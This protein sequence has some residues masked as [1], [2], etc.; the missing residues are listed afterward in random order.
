[1]TSIRLVSLAFLPVVAGFGLCLASGAP[2]GGAP[3]DSAKAAGDPARFLADAGSRVDAALGR[4][5]LAAYRG[6]LK[7][8]RLDAQTEALRGG[9]SSEPA[10][11]KAR[12]LDDWVRRI[13]DNPGLIG[14][15][16]GVEEWAYESLVDDSGQPFR[17][18]IPTDYD[19]AHP[20]PL[21]VYMHGYS[22][23]HIEHSAGMVP[24]PGYF[25]VSVLGRSR[26]GGFR[27]LSEADVLQVVDYVTAHWAIDPDR[28]SL[29]GGS[30][31]GGATYRLGSRYPQL[32]CSGRT[33][34]GFASYLPLGNLVTLPIYATHSADDPTVSVLHDRGPLARLREIG[35]QVIY[36]ETNGYGHAVWN[37]K[38]GNARGLAWEQFQVRPA[39]RTVRRVDYTALDGGAVRGWWGEVAEWGA[40]PK[41]ARFV[42]AAGN[43]NLLF[44][45]LTNIARLRLFLSESPFERSM[46]LEVSVNGAVPFTLPAPLPES[47]VIALGEKGWGPESKAEV[48]P[49]RLHTPGS[50]VLLYDGEP[51]LIVY[52]TRGSETERKAMRAAAEAASKGPGPAWPDEKVEAG[53]DKVPHN[54]NLYGR[55]NIKADLDVTA[56]DVARCHLVLIGTAAQN[57]VV[58][59]MADALPVRFSDTGVTCSDGASFRGGRLAMGLVH[60]NPLAPGRLIFWVASGD[61]AAYA[62]NSAIPLAMSGGERVPNPA[63]AFGADLV[64]MSA[65]SPTLVAARSFDSR[66]RWVPG[67]GESPLVPGNIANPR[68]LSRAVGEAI[69][70]AAG[71]DFALVKTD[72]PLLPPSATAGVT[73]VSD[74][75]PFFSNTPVGEFEASGAELLEIARLAAAKDPGLVMP[76]L[77]AARI[78]AARAYRVAL[79]VN[80]L[81]YF[82]VAVQPAPRNY[83]ITGLDAGDAVERF[84]PLEAGG[85][86]AP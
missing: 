22:G 18:D 25:E 81:W 42:L 60:Y 69:R 84:F 13:A 52:G 3:D 55:L 12:R 6:W 64:V 78:V 33:T 34:C 77:D 58:A 19:D 29:N 43:P 8:L 79:P 10:L 26:G 5:D 40:S 85:L 32:W 76:G 47:A 9:A 53:P 31:G 46:P 56:G 66:W 59:R 54:Q 61:P 30:M 62:G 35:G 11:A 15:L 23:N 44:A 24:H 7:Y 17:I 83:W 67:R 75:V 86:T 21:S 57:G 49:F 48:L 38:E 74:L 1:M 36:D 27:A 20:A 16:R 2:A 41:P 39:S 72:I 51:L 14:T 28:I 73:R 82:S 65:A 80:V 63:N 71:A 70:R 68:D 50:A 37:Y 45:D 4:A